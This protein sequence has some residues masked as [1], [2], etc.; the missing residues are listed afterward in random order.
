MNFGLIGHFLLSDN[1]NL[2]QVI[3]AYWY[4]FYV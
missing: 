4:P 1:L 3:I 2:I